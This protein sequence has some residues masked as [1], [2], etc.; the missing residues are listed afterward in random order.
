MSR[1]FSTAFKRVSLVG[2]ALLLGLV[3]ACDDG[4]PGASDPDDMPAPF[5]VTGTPAATIEVAG[6]ELLDVAPN[7]SSALVVG[8][9]TLSLVQIGA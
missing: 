9:T 5:A 6:A 1:V 3:T 2:M 4:V 8:G 7:G